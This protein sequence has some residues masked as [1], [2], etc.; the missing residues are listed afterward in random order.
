MGRPRIEHCKKC[1][2][3]SREVGELSLAKKCPSCGET[4]QIQNRRELIAHN[5]QYF[6]HW[7][8]RIAASVGATLDGP[9]GRA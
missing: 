7:R 9:R 1:G 6:E 8:Q 4:A 2:H 3:P 5:G